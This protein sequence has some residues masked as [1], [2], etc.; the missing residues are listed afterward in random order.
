MKEYFSDLLGMKGVR[1]A[2]LFG[3]DG[4]INFEAFTGAGEPE[5]RNFANW[6]AVAT[7]LNGVRESD[8]IFENGRFYIRRTEWGI[9]LVVMDLTVS[10]AMV[11]LNCDIL[12]PNLK[13]AAGAKGLK[14][15]FR[16]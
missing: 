12:L 13:Q 3:Q 9:L 7:A 8:L 4:A 2:V 14:R 6:G 16:K 11:K 10:V 15:F 5:A 1:G